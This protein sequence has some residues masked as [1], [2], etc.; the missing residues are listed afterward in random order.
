MEIGEIKGN[1]E[2]LKKLME[3]QKD[4]NVTPFLGAG[5]SDPVCP[6]WKDFLDQ[7]YKSVQ[8]I[9]MKDIDR[10]NFE[11][12][13][14]SNAPTRLED[15]AYILERCC[16]RRRFNEEIEAKFDKK[17][18]LG[19][20]RKFRLLH[21]AFP[22]LK[23]TSNFDKLIEDNPFGPSVPVIHI[24]KAEAL[25]Y[26]FAPHKKTNALV[27]IHGGLDDPDSIILTRKQYQE[28]Y[29]SKDSFSNDAPLPKFL[30]LLFTLRSVLFIGCSLKA[31]RL[32]MVLQNHKSECPHFA[33]REIPTKIKNGENSEIDEDKKLEIER[34]CSKHGITPIWVEKYKQI[35]EL[36]QMLAPE[37][38]DIQ[39]PEHGI[40]FVGREGHLQ[41]MKESLFDWQ[42][43]SDQLQVP[44]GRI[45]VLEGAGG[46]G[47]TTLAI[48]AVKKFYSPDRFPDGI[49]GPIRADEQSPQFF[50][51][52]LS[53]HFDILIKEP[54]SKEAAQKAIT[55]ILREKQA[56][57]ILDNV[58]EWDNLK[59]LLPSETLSTIL[60]TTR[61]RDIAKRIRINVNDKLKKESLA[62]EI[63]TQPEV[64]DLFRKMLDNYNPNDHHLYLDI[65]KSLG[66]L[67]LALRQ[68]LMLVLFGENYT[69]QELRDK[70]IQDE[71]LDLL[72]QGHQLDSTEEN[73]SI[74]VVFDLSSNLLKPRHLK[75]LQYMATC[76]PGPIPLE[77]LV[78]LTKN[79]N[80]R[81]DLEYLH[82]RSWCQ[83]QIFQKERKYGLHQLVR[84]LVR[85]RFKNKFAMEYF[86]LVHKIFTDEEVH[87]SVK[88]PL[89]PELEVAFRIAAEKKD[90][91]LKELIDK[92]FDFCYS[93]G[94]GDLFI[95]LSQSAIKIFPKDKILFI[96]A[97]LQQ[98]K[99]KY[100]LGLRE[101]A[102]KMLKRIETVCIDLNENAHLASCYSE[103]SKIQKSKSGY[104][105]ALALLQKAEDI[106]LK[107]QDMEGF[108]SCLGEQ[109]LLI[110]KGGKKQ[111]AMRLSERGIEIVKKSGNKNGL[112]T[113]YYTL[114]SL[115]KTFNNPK[116]ALQ[117][118]E[119]AEAIHE[120]KN[121][122]GMAF[123]SNKRASILCRQ[124]KFDEAIKFHEK[125][126]KINRETGNQAGLAFSYNNHVETLIKANRLQKALELSKKAEQIEK[127]SKNMAGL[128]I[129]YK[130]AGKILN[131]MYLHSEA[132]EMYKK[133]GEIQKKLGNK[134]Y[135]SSCYCKQVEIL[136]RLGRLSEA[137]IIYNKYEQL[138]KELNKK[139]TLTECYQRKVGIFRLQNRYDEALE[140]LKKMESSCLELDD[141]RKLANCYEN[142]AA[143][144]KAQNKYDGALEKLKKQEKICTKNGWKKTLSACNKSQI[145]IYKLQNRYDEALGMLKKIE[146][147]SL[148]AGDI[149]GIKESYTIQ[150]AILRGQKKYDESI[151]K[152]KMLED[153][154]KKNGRLSALADCY[155]TQS[156][157]Y[158]DQNKGEKCL[159]LLEQRELI[160]IE[161][162]KHKAL[163]RCYTINAIHLKNLSR[164]TEA[165]SKQKKCEEIHKK[166]KN[167]EG[168]ADSWWNIGSIYGEMGEKEE[169]ISSWNQSIK[170]KQKIGIP[171]EENIKALEEIKQTIV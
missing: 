170:L 55:N 128:G 2:S 130:R 71:R 142:Q 108:A 101:E 111:E 27:K 44:S 117:M 59:Y 61:N 166:F 21:K 18:P 97:S 49:I 145:G 25:N 157:I 151:T 133:E 100:R 11:K 82:S 169:Q 40:T 167:H 13:Q 158:K 60:L 43:Q 64:E 110:S 62:L 75:I 5:F 76:S 119:K 129:C 22:G 136:S 39:M 160:Y 51:N 109:V 135:L 12:A 69:I 30:T 126:K 147:S 114:A 4:G 80:V 66:F 70:L 103:Q 16:E 152:L 45:F 155:L 105:T 141:K 90:E 14:N 138:Y 33:I 29:G 9:F 116:H 84:E 79:P 8:N 36:L 161:L 107:L 87:F 165:L 120:K 7:Y 77:F 132:L 92:L 148:E 67:P 32:L 31:D 125:A 54:E 146:A 94:Y 37:E 68:A 127:D 113:C 35:E 118:L 74:E 104:D 95:K 153:I 6:M 122:E 38:E 134:S 106:Y 20:R 26:L 102:M 85:T 91:R 1:R 83:R 15:M 164:F 34:H 17:L 139:S 150:A 42:S 53:N 137:L 78:E 23:V 168:L 144:L 149:N 99:V 81:E 48:E 131:K 50:A 156:A 52:S 3:W 24:S 143:I 163:A 98:A 63:F 159:E 28:F 171:T 47:K 121:L 154:L 123:C 86:E 140:L 19:M 56:I 41:Q 89:V 10:K 96:V 57:I 65:A 72:R 88:D 58:V 162:G 73:R 115:L 112:A 93:R 46:I 124:N